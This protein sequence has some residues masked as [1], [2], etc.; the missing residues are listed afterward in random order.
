MVRPKYK[1]DA[2]KSG[3]IITSKKCFIVTTSTISK[4]QNMDGEKG[5]LI[6]YTGTV[7][8]KKEEEKLGYEK[9]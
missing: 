2:N 8:I 6:L 3:H 9:I 7:V 5:K 1:E 4:N